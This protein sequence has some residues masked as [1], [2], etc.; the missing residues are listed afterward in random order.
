M[1]DRYTGDIGDYGKYGLL[2]FIHKET[3]LRLGVNWYL[4]DPEEVDENDSSDGKKVEYLDKEANSIYDKDLF[5]ELKDIVKNNRTVSEIAKRNILYSGTIFY[6][7]LISYRNMQGTEIR[8]EAREKWFDDSLNVFKSCDVI[9]LDP[10]NGIRPPK[11]KE[12]RKKGVKYVIEDEVRK[13][14]SLEKS[15]IIYNHKSHEK[16]HIYSSRFNFIKNLTER[17]EIPS[18]RYEGVRDYIFV[19]QSNHLRIFEETLC[20]FL[21]TNWGEKFDRNH[22]TLR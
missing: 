4:V 21:K 14:Y 13:Y 17:N 20:N 15:L 18:L 12:Y 7:K 22:L 5:S 3:G 6:E 1:Q 19:L 2:R 10:D 16:K 11:T 9:F 8:K